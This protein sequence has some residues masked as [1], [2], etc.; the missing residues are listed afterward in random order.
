MSTAID[1]RI[2]ASL[3]T[4]E[5]AQQA[6]TSTDEDEP[7]SNVDVKSAHLSLTQIIRTAESIRERL[8]T[9]VITNDGPGNVGVDPSSFSTS[10]LD[11]TVNEITETFDKRIAEKEPDFPT[12][13]YSANHG[14]D[15]NQ[16]LLSVPIQ[17]PTDIKEQEVC[18]SLGK[19]ESPL[20]VLYLHLMSD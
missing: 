9:V 6:C 10:L 5:L 16:L 2:K 3:A 19:F 12:R 7:L 8:P 17:T 1:D 14:S 13:P 15:S 20:H 11:A 4:L 18:C